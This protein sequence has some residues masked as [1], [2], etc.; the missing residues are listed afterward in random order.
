MVDF[1][2]RSMQ[3]VSDIK[4]DTSK[5]YCLLVSHSIIFAVCSLD[6]DEL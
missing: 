3:L 5:N 6:W 2:L 1:I 4:N